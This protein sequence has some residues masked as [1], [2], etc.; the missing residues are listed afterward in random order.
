MGLGVARIG[1]GS[2]LVLVAMLAVGTPC[3]A[4]AAGAA[5]A[6]P[7]EVA[8]ARLV[9]TVWTSEYGIPRPSGLAFVAS[10]NEFVVAG[11][12][13]TVT[14]LVR[15]ARDE[16]S[17]GT[18]E[19][20]AL[21]DPS[22]LA[23][24]AATNE[25][26]AVSDDQLVVAPGTNLANRRPG[27]ARADISGL[28]LRDAR[29][30]TYDAATGTWFVLDARAPA[31]VRIGA[32]GSHPTAPAR[33]ALADLGGRALR[34]LAF[35]PAD[36]LLYVSADAHLLY[37]IDS[38]GKIAK[39]YDLGDTGVRNPVAMTFAPST[40]KTDA[41]A[42]QNLFVADSGDASMLGGVTEVTLAPQAALAAP[43]DSA[44]L[45]RTIDTSAFSP[46]SP[47]PSG[48]T[49]IPSSDRLEICDSEVEETTGA[50]YH[51]VN[52][53]QLTRTGTVTDT[54]TT[55]PA[56]SKE[57]NGLG[58]IAASNTLLISDD[59]LRRIHLM[60]AGPDGRFGTAD[61][62]VTFI[63]AFQYGSVDT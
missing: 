39:T 8:R 52:M 63:N 9:R 56:I 1:S 48:V 55:F 62:V 43:V 32:R 41:A 33:T 59:S 7:G 23:F 19:L 61:D 29:G 51:G 49:Y 45:V 30:A 11:S 27:T 47:D 10:R 37:G 22:T 25:L 2:R 36:G 3:L 28:G 18:L 26:S 20:P 54:G 13:S 50:G 16:T 35:N 44:T 60:K 57:P 4:H 15:L 40:D 31:I 46:A 14:P 58:Y 42:N 12:P 21:T 24:D 53:W 17:P 5:A 6:P 34:G 38:N